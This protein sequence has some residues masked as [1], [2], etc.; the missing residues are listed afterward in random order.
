MRHPTSSTHSICIY[1]PGDNWMASIEMESLLRSLS[2]F[3]FIDSLKVNST[4]KR[5]FVCCHHHTLKFR[6]KLNGFGIFKFTLIWHRQ[7]APNT[8]LYLSPFTAPC[9]RVFA[10][11]ELKS[12]RRC[13]RCAQSNWISQRNVVNKKKKKKDKTKRMKAKQ[14]FGIVGIF[15]LAWQIKLWFEIPKRFSTVTFSF[16][17]R[18]NWPQW[19]FFLPS[20]SI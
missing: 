5:S 2:N 4:R 20:Q 15:L 14:T 9:L 12:I 8:Q 10:K 3:H 19:F 17:A 16:N 7:N 13:T 18:R 1:I 11:L 6:L